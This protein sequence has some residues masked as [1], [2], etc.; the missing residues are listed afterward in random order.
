MHIDEYSKTIFEWKF[1]PMANYICPTYKV[2]KNESNSP[3]G[4]TLLLSLITG[5]QKRPFDDVTAERMYQCAS[6]YLCTSL[7]YDDSD[8]ASLFIAARA[9][10]VEKKLVPPVVLAH[11]EK[12]QRKT[13]LPGLPKATRNGDVAVVIDPVI[14]SQFPEELRANLA[15]LDSA[16]IS[17]GIVGAER[18]SGA[19]LFELGFF[20]EARE[21]AQTMREELTSK[22][23]RTR[24]FLSPYDYW[25][26][27]TGYRQIGLT[28]FDGVESIPY[29]AFLLRLVKE[30]R[31]R[32]SGAADREQKNRCCYLDAGHYVRPESSFLG[33]EDLLRPTGRVEYKPLWRGG[34]LAPNDAG[35][36]LPFIYPDL[37]AGIN[38]R[39]LVELSETGSKTVLVSC[40]Y[41]LL[42][43]RSA[44]ASASMAVEDLGS[45]LLRCL[46]T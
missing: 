32:F 34:R 26:L 43:L 31:L 25:F 10:I 24:V 13:E 2:T 3:R 18:A 16:G 6:C 14:S 42:N 28:G 45:F 12:L 44:A 5:D 23:Y 27:T 11:T 7:G 20:A 39:L 21:M 30:G 4:L 41:T 33:I 35:D 37:A 46:K 29:P 15:L 36:F 9:D 38:E 22:K 8:P 17:Y 19:Q 1:S 40:F